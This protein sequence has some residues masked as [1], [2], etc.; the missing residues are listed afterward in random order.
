MCMTAFCRNFPKNEEI[1]PKNERKPP[2]SEMEGK[3]P[4]AETILD[5]Y[6]G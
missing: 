6:L 3:G 1:L 2:N 5:L 4:E